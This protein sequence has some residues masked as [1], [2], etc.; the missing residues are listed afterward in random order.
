MADEEAGSKA[1]A[2]RGLVIGLGLGAVAS[3][4]WS[5]SRLR[6]FADAVERGDLDEA[7]RQARFAAFV[8]WP[9]WLRKPPPDLEGDAED[10][11]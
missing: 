4:L 7:Q 6:A 9:L 3:E 11:D 1:A 2:L 10:S 8:Y 5:R